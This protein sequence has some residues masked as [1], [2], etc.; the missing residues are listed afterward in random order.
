MDDRTKA[1]NWSSSHTLC[2]V[3]SVYLTDVISYTRWPLSD[4][5]SY[6]Y[7][8]SLNDIFMQMNFFQHFVMN[9]FKSQLGRSVR[10]KDGI[11]FTSLYGMTFML[12]CCPILSPGVAR[13]Q[14]HPHCKC[15][16]RNDETNE[17]ILRICKLLS[18]LNTVIIWVNE[19]AACL[20]NGYL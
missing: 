20:E 17:W 13:R 10:S 14:E 1:L 8:Q 4:L 7:Y 3:S 12:G 6:L 2:S 15:I 19:K 9:G 16:L 11:L 5:W 18:A